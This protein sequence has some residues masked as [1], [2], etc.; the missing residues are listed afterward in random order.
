MEN[1]L[2]EYK[3]TLDLVNL[4]DNSNVTTVNLRLPKRRSFS[5]DSGKCMLGRA[6]FCILM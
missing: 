1:E 2:T 6:L 3:S 5:S 4:E